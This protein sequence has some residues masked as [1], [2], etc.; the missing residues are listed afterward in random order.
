MG[1]SDSQEIRKGDPSM[2]AH[3]AFLVQLFE[4]ILALPGIVQSQFGAM[5]R[6]ADALD[7]MAAALNKSVLEPVLKDLLDLLD[8]IVSTYV[9]ILKKGESLRPSRAL[10]YQ[11]TAELVKGQIVQLISLLKRYGVRIVDQ[12]HV[13]FDPAIHSIERVE[14]GAGSGSVVTLVVRSGFLFQD[15]VLRKAVVVVSKKNS[16][17]CMEAYGNGPG[18]VSDSDSSDC[19]LGVSLP[20]GCPGCDS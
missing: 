6:Q 12:V 18:L 11:E 3:V 1:G 8:A 4:S 14:P 15:L 19:E 9:Q 2:D 5:R 17:E 16:V 20:E 13:A 7:G 10:P